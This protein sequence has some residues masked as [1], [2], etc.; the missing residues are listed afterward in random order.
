MSSIEP[1]THSEFDPARLARLRVVLVGAQHPGNIGA[2]AR[3]MKV[4]GLTD[5]AL[6]APER[7]P[8]PEAT[9][10]ASGAEDVLE[11][12]HLC[13][14]L[15]QAIGDCVLAIGASARRRSTSWPLVDAR[16]AARRAI[17]LAGEHRVALVFGCERSGLEN[18]ALDLCQLHLQVPTN[19]DYRSLNLAAAVQVVAYELRMAAGDAPEPEPIHESVDVAAME[20][21]YE[22]VES[23]LTASGF[24]DPVTPGVLM[25]RI[26]R[27]LN[28]ARPDR[29]EL[30]ILRG[31]MRSLDPRLPRLRR[32][33]AIDTSAQNDND[34]SMG[35][36]PGPHDPK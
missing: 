26:R 30:N 8:D 12:A 16:T 35:L 36:D 7:Y 22:H 2:A 29:I 3:A 10:R 9:A 25:R 21:L 19:P 24:L 13:E 18:A 23:V 17:E 15:E 5:L 27:L 11:A 20:G 14:T 6:V 31:V 4:M 1:Q 28:R 32:A 33:P 34:R